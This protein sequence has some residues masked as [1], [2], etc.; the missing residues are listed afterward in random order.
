M[1]LVRFCVQ[2]Q[3]MHARLGYANMVQPNFEPRCGSAVYPSAVLLIVVVLL[4]INK[5]EGDPARVWRRLETLKATFW[6]HSREALCATEGTT[7]DIHAPGIVC[8][9]YGFE[10]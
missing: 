5:L 4:L 8:S 9:V 6:R 2:G 3:V 1:A 7:K 10:G